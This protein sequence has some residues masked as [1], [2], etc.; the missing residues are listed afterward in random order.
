MKRKKI[1]KLSAFSAPIISCVMNGTVALAGNP[2]DK[3]PLLDKSANQA[4]YNTSVNAAFVLTDILGSIV[5]GFASVLGIFFIL[6]VIYGGYIWMNAR[7]N[8]S[9]VDRAKHIIRDAIIG[10]IVVTSSYSLWRLV[11]ALIF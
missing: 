3:N 7:G 6:L 8:S 2:I 4:G 5:F 9:E 11:E 1:I 10:L